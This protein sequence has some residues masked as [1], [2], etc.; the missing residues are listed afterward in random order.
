M[1]AVY[2]VGPTL[3][4]RLRTIEDNVNHRVEEDRR[5][6]EKMR[7]TVVAA[8][9]RLEDLEE[10]ARNSTRRVN[11][12]KDLEMRTAFLENKNM[13]ETSGNPLKG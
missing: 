1:V 6:L 12:I 8:G 11:T 4:D 7:G 13:I 2:I 5:D 9:R 3:E 10:G